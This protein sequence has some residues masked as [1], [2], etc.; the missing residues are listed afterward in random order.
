MRE[1]D[2]TTGSNTLGVATSRQEAEA[3]VT[4][5][6][7]AART[8]ESTESAGQTSHTDSATSDC[9][10]SGAAAPQLILCWKSRLPH[11]EEAFLRRLA[12]F[13]VLE[14]QPRDIIARCSADL[15]PVR[16]AAEVGP[17]ESGVGQDSESDSDFEG[18]GFE[19][20]FHNEEEETV[21]LMLGRLREEHRVQFSKE[22]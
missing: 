11:E 10:H 6:T 9:S 16:A 7:S 13:F 12:H 19:S 4:Q 20:L 15:D 1:P 14:E 8:A 22:V 17:A 5:A 2:D 18:G 3:E 21:R